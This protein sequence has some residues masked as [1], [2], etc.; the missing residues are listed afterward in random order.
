MSGP[1]NK[2]R[3]L[4]EPPDRQLF[5]RFVLPHLDA[6]YNV[7]R[8]LVRAE[9]DAFDVVQESLLRAWRYFASFRGHNESDARPWL[10]QIV[11]HSA[12]ALLESRRTQPLTEDLPLVDESAPDPAAELIE[13]VDA[14]L[15]TQAV[16]ALPPAYRE[17]IVL[18]ELESLSYKEICT[19][20]GASMG[21]VMSRLSR[22]RQQLLA[23]LSAQARKESRHDL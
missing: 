12:W 8:H 1:C 2:D 6:A 22:A 4:P 3:P 13:R 16:D 7:A 11:R 19:V 18:R 20:T 9:A 23:A 5:E 17:V 14:E 21:T 10:L 15:L